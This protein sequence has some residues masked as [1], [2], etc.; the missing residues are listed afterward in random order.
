MVGGLPHIIHSKKLATRRQPR[1]HTWGLSTR[2]C[3]WVLSSSLRLCDPVTPGG[4]W[5]ASLDGVRP[6]D[7]CV[8]PLYS[9]PKSKA[10]LNCALNRPETSSPMSV[11]VD[12]MN[13]PNILCRPSSQRGHSRSICCIGSTSWRLQYGHTDR[14]W[15]F[16]SFL[17]ASFSEVQTPLTLHCIMVW[18]PR[19][20][21]GSP[22]N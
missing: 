4:V 22:P 20:N 10:T 12:K 1:L 8:F 11:W 2:I 13:S 18:I 5:G 17:L 21:R 3:S 9:P 19:I 6:Q 7:S 14:Y 16:N 15:V